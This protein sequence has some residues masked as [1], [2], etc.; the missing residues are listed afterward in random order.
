VHLL[1]QAGYLLHFVDYNP[2]FETR[3]NKI[4]QPLGMSGQVIENLCLEEIDV[5]GSGKG[6]LHPCGLSGAPGSEQKK[7]L[8]FG[9]VDQSG[10]HNSILHI[11]LEVSREFI[12]IT[13]KIIPCRCFSRPQMSIVWWRRGKRRK[14]RLRAR[15][16]GD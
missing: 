16:A 15:P 1:E 14:V 4:G 13:E 11:F 5:D 9:R 6:G 8:V 10:I 2:V 12:T 3:R 7:T